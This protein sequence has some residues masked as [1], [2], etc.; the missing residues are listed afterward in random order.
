MLDGKKSVAQKIVYGAF[1]QAEE[2]AGKPALEIFEAAMSISVPSD[3]SITVKQ[4]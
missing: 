1:S 3:T 4:P 2:K